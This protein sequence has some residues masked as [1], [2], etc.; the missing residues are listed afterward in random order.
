MEPLEQLLCKTHVYTNKHSSHA[1]ARDSHAAARRTAARCI[2]SGPTHH[3]AH[4]TYNW[5]QAALVPQPPL[6]ALAPLSQPA[7]AVLPRVNEPLRI[8]PPPE[9][10][11]PDRGI[12]TVVF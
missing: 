10:D 8:E 3:K 1:A 7:D 11:A 6:D 9:Y 4:L 12:L 5:P 2:T